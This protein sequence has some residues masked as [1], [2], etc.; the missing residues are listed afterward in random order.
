MMAL[1]DFKKVKHEQEKKLNEDPIITKI[2]QRRRQV[3]VHSC[4]Y[5]KF[6]ESIIEDHVYDKYARELKS[7]VTKYPDKAKKAVFSEKFKEWDALPDFY[8]GFC[9]PLDDDWVVHKAKQLLQHKRKEDN[10]KVD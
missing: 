6:D 5:Y 7:L 9:L 2:N 3:L 10:E 1:F 4:L 8:S